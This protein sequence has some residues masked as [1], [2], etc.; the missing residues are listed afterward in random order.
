MIQPIIDGPWR[1]EGSE[2]SANLLYTD[3]TF[4]VVVA[5]GLPLLEVRELKVAVS[6]VVGHVRE[7]E[8]KHGAD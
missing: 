4:S 8:R 5:M 1:I 3:G 6:E 2:T 7:Q